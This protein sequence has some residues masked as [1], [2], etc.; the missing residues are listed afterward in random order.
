MKII[1]IIIIIIIIET[2][3]AV[4]M[5]NMPK[6]IGTAYAVPL[7]VKGLIV[8]NQ[9]VIGV[10]NVPCQKFKDTNPNIQALTSFHSS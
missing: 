3:K 10:K 2:A 5:A 6:I 7:A 9:I 4:H 1:I 8:E